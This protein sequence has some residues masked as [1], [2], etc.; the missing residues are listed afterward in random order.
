MLTLKFL[1]FII[2]YLKWF[3]FTLMKDVDSAYKSGLVFKVEHMFTLINVL[4]I[5]SNFS[6]R[7]T[8]YGSVLLIREPPCSADTRKCNFHHLLISFP[9][10]FSV[11]FFFRDT[12]THP[13]FICM[14]SFAHY[15]LIF[16]VID[17]C[18][19]SGYHNWN[20]KSIKICYIILL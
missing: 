16:I 1:L 15:F 10:L 5:C 11:I 12:P 4:D 14:L 18:C 13:L 8:N 6:T 7:L 20:I 9:W 19:K 2:N 3:C 17:S